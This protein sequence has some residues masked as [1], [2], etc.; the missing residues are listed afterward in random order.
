LPY[1]S[2]NVN[3]PYEQGSGTAWSTNAQ[4]VYF[5]I[6]PSSTVSTIY[7]QNTAVAAGTAA[8]VVGYQVGTLIYRTA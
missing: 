3:T 8:N 1:T 5:L 7:R 6:N 4:A 2:T